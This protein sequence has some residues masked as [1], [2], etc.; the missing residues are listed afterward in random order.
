MS[1]GLEVEASGIAIV[2]ENSSLGFRVR[3]CQICRDYE[4][5]ISG[6]YAHGGPSGGR[7]IGF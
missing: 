1:L 4:S 7:H 2:W 6:D 5:N 3:V